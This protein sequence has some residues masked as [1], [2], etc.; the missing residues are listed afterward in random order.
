MRTT[1][2]PGLALLAGALWLPGAA[3]PRKAELK[4]PL[5]PAEALAEFRVAPGLRVELVASEP[6][7]QSPVAMAFDEDGRLWV[8]EMRDYP[9][10]PPKGRPPEGRIVILEEDSSGRY[11][12]KSVFADRLLFANGLLPWRGGAIVT[13]APHIL[14][15][16][17]EKRA[18]KVQRR[19]VLFEGFAAERV[20]Y[21]AGAQEQQGFEKGVS[22]QMIDAGGERSA[23]ER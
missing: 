12:R 8:V 1:L 3:P 22:H 13:C 16:A 18:G 19:E 15:L 21:A 4:S 23:T 6:D 7:V 20:N 11:K 9:N 17:D 2:L 5:S 10:G 14:Y